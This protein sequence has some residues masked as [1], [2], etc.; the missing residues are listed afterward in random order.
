M[1]QKLESPA[2]DGGA[3]EC[4][5]GRLDG[6][7]FTPEFDVAQLEPPEKRETQVGQVVPPEKPVGN[8]SPPEQ[9]KGFAADTAEKIGM[10]KRSINRCLE[11]TR[12]IPQDVRDQ[13]K[14]THLDT[15]AYLDRI[16]KLPPDEQRD[17]RQ[18]PERITKDGILRGSGQRS[19]GCPGR[20]ARNRDDIGANLEFFD[21]LL[22]LLRL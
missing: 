5:A 22:P 7:K 20:G 11:R 21:N 8:K 18:Q 1:T 12:L 14:R 19:L 2:G 10:S 6:S 9:K 16:K 3:F 15:G 13:I 17:L 4:L